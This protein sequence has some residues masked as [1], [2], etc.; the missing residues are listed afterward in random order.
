MYR[1]KSP[2]ILQPRPTGKEK[3]IEDTFSLPHITTINPNY[4]YVYH[5]MFILLFT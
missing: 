3:S 5:I 4:Y 2:S 1:Q